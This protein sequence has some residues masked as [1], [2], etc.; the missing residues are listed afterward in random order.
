MPEDLRFTLIKTAQI[1][2]FCILAIK[3]DFRQF[4]TILMKKYRFILEI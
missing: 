3:I 1:E 2:K 4:K